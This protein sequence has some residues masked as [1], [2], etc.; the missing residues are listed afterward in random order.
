MV[1]LQR[2]LIDRAARRVLM[3]PTLNRFILNTLWNQYI[4]ELGV[5]IKARLLPIPQVELDGDVGSITL[6]NK[7]AGEVWYEVFLYLLA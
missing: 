6:V 3:K 1:R 2:A 7:L 5:L 4:I